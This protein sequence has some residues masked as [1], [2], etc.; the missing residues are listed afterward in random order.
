MRHERLNGATFAPIGDA[1]AHE[2]LDLHVATVSKNRGEEIRV[3]LKEFKGTRFLD[4]RAFVTAK[5][6]SGTRHPTA[7][8]VT[9]N[10][11]RIDELMDAL[12]QARAEALRLGLLGN[13][14]T[15]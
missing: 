3:S 2:P 7:K 6:D 14:R 5:D 12:A 4:V 10:P 15:A 13:G 9:L 11:A 8:G 1:C